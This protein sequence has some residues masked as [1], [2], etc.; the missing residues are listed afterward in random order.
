MAAIV[1]DV[2]ERPYTI[3]RSTVSATPNA[4]REVILPPWARTFTIEA[5]PGGVALKVAR[6]GADEVTIAADYVDVVAGAGPREFVASS[7][8]Q[9]A[10]ITS[11][12]VAS[13][14][15][16]AVFVVEAEAAER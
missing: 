5:P 8:Q 16:S 4:A 12:F 2:A 7:G 9:S 13:V 15:V 11:V 3:T 6:T 1:L 10:E 14:G